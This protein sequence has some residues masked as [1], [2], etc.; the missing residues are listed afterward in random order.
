MPLTLQIWGSLFLCLLLAGG[1]QSGDQLIDLKPGMVIDESMTIRPGTYF[2]PA[3][4]STDQ[5]MLTITGNDIV[6]DFNGVQLI[7]AEEDALPDAYSGLAVLIRGG[8]NITIR[9]L[10]ARGYKVAL[11]A[12]EVDSLKLFDCNLSYNYRQR[13]FSRR[14]RENFADWLSYHDNERDQWLRY[15][16]AAYLKDCR[17]AV[18]RGLQVTGGQNGLLLNGCD[19]GLFYNND[20]RFN[21]GVG[22]GLY[23]SSGNRIMHN[24]L[25]WNV[26]GYSHEVYSRGQDSAGILCY[27]QSNRNIFAYNS[28][29]HSG[30]GFFLWAGNQ[31]MNSGEGGCNDNIIFQNDFSHAPTN[32]VEVTFSRNDIVNNRLVG[33]RYGVWAGYSYQTLILGNTIAE[34]Q[35]GVAIEHGNNNSINA[36]LFEDNEVGIQLW[37]RA[38]QPADW[39]FAQHRDVSS[40]S[41]T[42]ET[43]VFAGTE[44]P[45]QISSSRDVAISDNTFLDFDLLFEG[46]LPGE[47]LSFE[48]NTINQTVGLG[49]ALP[50][51]DQNTLATDEDIPISAPENLYNTSRV[52]ALPDGQEVGLPAGHPQGRSFILIDEWGPYDFGYPA[53]WWRGVEEDTYVFL[54]LGPQGNWKLNG[55]AGFL[56]VNPKTGTFPSTVTAVRDPEAQRLALDFEFIGEAFTDRFGRPVTRGTATPFYFRDDEYPLR[57]RVRWYEYGEMQHPVD[58]YEAF[59][60]LTEGIPGYETETDTLAFVWWNSPGGQIAPD[61]FATFAETDVTL[62]P[63]RYRL[64]LTSDDGVRLYID[65]DLLIDR[66]NVHTSIVDR[67]ELRLGGAHHIEVEHFDAGGLANLDVRLEVIEI[68]ELE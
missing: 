37:A 19:E 10:S 62:P 45:L 32:G 9:N 56:R 13:L 64:E 22:I 50:F 2:M 25:D 34:N 49:G 48:A 1:C 51:L 31:T 18:V 53:V 30:D 67:R 11:L 24:R 39:G 40:R 12:E 54:L 58:Q 3:A 29:T 38:E 35:Y 36:N 66:W 44:I 21:S 15:G 20:I 60:S 47:A 57:W 55:G 8:S 33:C 5:P 4:D 59:R 41:Y 16:A 52:Q 7:G 14:D 42:I 28:A 23:R 61:R 6:V 26:R 65:G 17:N 63:G 46:E 68:D 27:E 43:N